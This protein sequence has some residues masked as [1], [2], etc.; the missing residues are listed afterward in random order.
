[1]LRREKE[2]KKEGSYSRY[3]SLRFSDHNLSLK[4][5]VELGVG[6]LL[7]FTI[8]SMWLNNVMLRRI[9]LAVARGQHVS[10]SHRFLER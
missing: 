1:M 5:P 6:V 8:C 3:I 2:D 4:P 10:T 9:K 7:V